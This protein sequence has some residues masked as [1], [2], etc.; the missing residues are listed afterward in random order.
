MFQLFKV[1][2]TSD[3]EIKI[4]KKWEVDKNNI[5]TWILNFVNFV[6]YES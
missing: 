1:F 3:H 6:I 2:K 5:L 4:F